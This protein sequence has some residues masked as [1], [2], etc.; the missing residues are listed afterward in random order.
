M[1]AKFC[2]LLLALVFLTAFLCA[3]ALADE[4]NCHGATVRYPVYR[5]SRPGPEEAVR[6]RQVRQLRSLVHQMERRGHGREAN[7]GAA[8]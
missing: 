1:R 8:L 3:A 5:I 7:K 4:K 6:R 2:H